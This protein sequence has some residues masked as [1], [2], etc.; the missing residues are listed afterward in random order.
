[1]HSRGELPDLGRVRL[2]RRD[3]ITYETYLRDALAK[4]VDF[5]SYSLYFPKSAGPELIESFGPN[6]DRPSHDPAGRQL[7]IPLTLSG[8]LLGVFAARGARLAAPKTEMERL[9]GLA[10]LCLERVLLYKAA[11]SDPVTGLG[12]REA[13][14]TAVT[15]EI[16]LVQDRILPGS[17]SFADPS[18][19]G[20]RGCFGLVILDLDGYGRVSENH[21][22][23][24]AESLL[25][26]VG[27]LL[28]GICP[29]GA[30]AARLYHDVFAVFLPGAV[31]ARCRE[32]CE[33]AR[34]A[35]ARARFDL[36]LTGDTLA[37]T[38][39]AGYACYPRDIKGGQF[40]APAAEQARIMLKKAQKALAAAKDLGRDQV[41]PF[42][43]ILAE[44][45]LVL[46]RLPLS[47]LGVSLGRSVEAEPGQRFLVWS[48]RYERASEIRKSDD[49][50][51]RGRYPTMIKGEI[52]L[53]EVRE[54]MA[55]AEVLHL[56]DPAWEI[57][58]GDRLLLA[59]EDAEA[60]GHEAAG[61]PRKDKVSGLFGHRDFLRFLSAARE[62]TP[63]FSLILARLP[64]AAS[65]RG[66]RRP[67]EAEAREAAE[68]CL[69]VFRGH[70]L[71]AEGGR[72]SSARLVF[73]LPGAPPARAFELAREAATV[74]QARLGIEPAAGVAGYPGLHLTKADVLDN[75]RKALDHAL[76]LTE[77]PRVALFDSLSLTINADRLFAHGEIYAAIEEYRLALAA[78]EDNVL[79][80][81]SLGIC[82]ARM[83]RLAEARAEFEKVIARDPKNTMALYNL[84][85]VRRRLGETALA[86]KAFQKC[87]K[88]NPGHVY[89]L[90]RL[91]RM[92]EEAKRHETAL[93]YYR[94]A[95]GAEGGRA[96]TMRHLAR[97]A[98]KRKRPAE[99][100]EH[101]H[102]ALLAD[103]KDAFSLSLLA[104]LYLD[105]GED[106]AMAEALA[107]QSVALR[108]ERKE[109]WRELAR[110][111]EAQGKADAA[112]D[113]FARAG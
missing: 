111:L 32:V 55:F 27:G 78:D 74:C 87:L 8:T 67:L 28:S 75:C 82:L 103:P 71:E 1:M 113:A 39:S 56:S 49:E 86:R 95:A 102:Q 7:L 26:Q 43:R 11:V 33:A 72:F 17:A 35:L 70:G 109:F 60:N 59:P 44:G 110:A 88:A 14:L 105:G 5:T 58:P 6:L 96:A 38:A 46:E 24:F 2:T 90:L 47:R 16:D 20:L 48:P 57:E 54:D 84:G 42:G 104:R 92:A 64:D 101:L 73:F 77:R 100:R 34:E 91:G 79:A 65:R 107:R 53:A 15:R 45:G 93:T 29:E 94:R 13:L 41:M 10:A 69:S 80:R 66:D 106:P 83:G 108:P 50:R 30:L 25:F 23:V 9:P 52:A 98:I 63:V 51:L 21:G 62:K 36:P 12:S 40:V 76:L 4:V 31:S 19:S 61:Q 97:L 37:L 112:K 89:S 18:L 85:C 99:A 22:F 3:L 81:N 68:V